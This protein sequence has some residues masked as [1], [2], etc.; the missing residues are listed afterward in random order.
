MLTFDKA[1]DGVRGYRQSQALDTWHYCSNCS[2]WPIFNY[3]ELWA[4]P[5]TG[6]I[7]SECEQKRMQG[8]CRS[9]IAPVVYKQN[10][11]YSY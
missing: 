7:C 9:D 6:K 10:Y 2:S 11:N 8:N 5:T 3:I 1:P 4:E